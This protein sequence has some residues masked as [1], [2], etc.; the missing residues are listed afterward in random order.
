MSNPV[1]IEVWRGGRVE[2]RHRGSVAVVDADGATVFA[3]GDV[4]RAVYPRSAIK[5]FQALPLIESGAADRF[6][7]D[8]E[9]IALACAS[10]NGE[11][12]HAATAARTLAA[13]GLDVSALACG[14][15]WPSREAT[16]RAL[17][18][19]GQE[20]SALHN[21][22][23]GKHSGFVCA[24]C[25]MGVDHHGYVD[26]AHPLQR[27]VQAGIERLAGVTLEAP[28]ID[29]CSAPNWP[30][31]LR[32]LAGAFARFGTGRGL[33]PETTKAA[34][35]LRAACAAKPWFVAGTERFCTGVMQYFGARVF[36]KT[37]AEGVFTGAFPDLGLGVALKVDDGAKRAAE[38]TMAAMIARFVPLTDAD[39]TF[40]DPFLHP[41]IRNWNGM[42]VG[43]LKLTAGL[44]GR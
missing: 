41:V 8:D 14:A 6:K 24:A 43:A 10:H 18:R 28:A 29:G 42:D 15:H 5:A 23:S 34:A 1:L 44:G 2:S 33:G 32:A 37:G 38:M 16:A 11:P 4:E 21:N 17:A 35:R 22:C 13:A 40:L 20:P 39:R 19:A 12:L 3:L 26:P 25:A 9:Q 31:P 36:V 27:E 30:V 7:L